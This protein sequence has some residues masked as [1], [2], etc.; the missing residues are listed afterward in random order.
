MDNGGRLMQYISDSDGEAN[1][2]NTFTVEH[3]FNKHGERISNEKENFFA[4]IIGNDR[5]SYYYIR[6]HEGILFDPAGMNSY[7][8]KFV[9]TKMKKVSKST[10]DFYMIYL[11]TKNNIYLTRAQRSF[12]DG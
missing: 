2:T 7:R 12:L 4:K 1:T 3:V 8:V 9:D 10:F 6:T 11:K 5:N